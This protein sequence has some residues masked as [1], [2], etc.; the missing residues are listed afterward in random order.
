M[1]LTGSVA[2]VVGP[3]IAGALIAAI[4]AP[5]AVAVD[6]H[7]FVASAGSVL[8]MEHREVLPERTADDPKPAMVREVKEGLGFLLGHRWMRPIAAS[9]GIGNFSISV[10]FS[11]LLLYMTRRLGLSSVEV[12]AVFA[13]GSLG[14]VGAALTSRR[15]QS[16]IGVGPTIVLATVLS[17]GIVA[18]P[19]A[20]RSFP[21]PVLMFGQLLFGFAVVAY[22][23][24]NGAFVRRSPRIDF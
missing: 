10:S 8:R 11:V 18:F 22:N 16:T 24:A 5:Y 13:V 6:A 2:Q 1:E 14:S 9:I 3:S 17:C 7:S 20:P 19:L 15:L 21:L 23:V 12:G 4:T